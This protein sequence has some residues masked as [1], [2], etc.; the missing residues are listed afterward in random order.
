MK[1][2][3]G[4]LYKRGKVYYLRYVIEG[5]VVARRLVNAK[6]EPITTVEEAESA[7]ARIMAP[8]KLADRKTALE[9]LQA[10]IGGVAAEIAQAEAQTPALKVSDSWQAYKTAGNRREVGARTLANYECV[11]NA[12]AAWLKD[13][14]PEIQELR[15]VTFQIAEE[16]RTHLIARKVSGRTV[17]AHR[18]SLRLVFNALAE[19]ARLSGNP[20]AKLAKRDEHQQGR[21]TLTVE[22]LRDVCAKAKGELRTMLAMGLYLGC[23]L[24]DA[25]MMDW[26]SVDLIRRLII[27]VPHKTARKV[28]EPLH[29]PIHTELHAILSE[30]RQKRRH[31]P[32]CPEMAARYSTRGPDAVSDLIQRHFEKCGLVTNEDRH[33][34]GVRRRVTVG[35]HSLRHTAVSLL[36]TAGV[37]Q[38][39]SMAIAGHTDTVV[40]QLYT[41]ADDEAMRR[42]VAA[43]PAMTGKGITHRPKLPPH[44][45]AA[46]LLAKIRKMK[47]E[48]IKR[49]VLRVL[50]KAARQTGTLGT[51]AKISKTEPNIA[52]ARQSAGTKALAP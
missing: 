1:T 19:R 38:S 41:H 40:H 17:N 6:D 44:A 22:E 43:L 12:F 3:T 32:V 51:K 25:A 50:A 30:T 47:P 4:T 27:Y 20:W 10:K 21:R 18:D 29:I 37:A 36:R 11:W 9:T 26:G 34:A 5:I 46:R 14:H 42:A 24:G 35:F 23:R 49:H 2:R 48:A 7:R 28:G 15:H 33:G 16:Y 31:G 45:R 8:L 52:T 13:Q 39:I